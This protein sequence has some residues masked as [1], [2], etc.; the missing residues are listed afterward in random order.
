MQARFA[1]FCGKERSSYYGVPCRAAGSCKDIIW[2]ATT[3]PRVSCDSYST[4]H[5]V[6]SPSRRVLLYCVMPSSAVKS[7]PVPLTETDEVT[8][9]LAT[10]AA[11][12]IDST[13]RVTRNPRA[14]HWPYA[15]LLC[16]LLSLV[17]DLGDGITAAPEV[18]LFE[19]A[20]CRDYYRTHEPRLI[21][22]TP[23][24][25]VPEKYC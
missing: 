15:A 7:M 12:D 17:A 23:L 18:R 10:G 24:S 20:V 2:Q 11:S 14:T 16:G 9:L 25:Y 1:R 8:P 6:L 22:L 5:S 19:M 13:N 21:G 4:S 3:L